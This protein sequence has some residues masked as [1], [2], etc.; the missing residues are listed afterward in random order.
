MPKR[1]LEG[2]SRKE[3][4]VP[5]SKLSPNSESLDLK[6]PVPSSWSEFRVWVIKESEGMENSCAKRFI[7]RV[8]KAIEKVSG[9][10][11]EVQSADLNHDHIGDEGSSEMETSPA[12]KQEYERGFIEIFNDSKHCS[13][14]EK[15]LTSE[16]TAVASD[17]NLKRPRGRPRREG[18]PLVATTK[19]EAVFPSIITTS[20][21]NLEACLE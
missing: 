6:H 16:V 7:L 19:V 5:A 11:N 4:T 12:L 17:G 10:S 20:S 15:P 18:P 13:P 3:S 9:A 1:I 14:A 2:V 8:V 21:P